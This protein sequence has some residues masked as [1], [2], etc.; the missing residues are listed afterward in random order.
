MLSYMYTCMGCVMVGRRKLALSVRGDLVD[1]VRRI[2]AERGES[3]SSI[4][5]EYLEY[6]AHARWIDTLAENLKLG[7]LK[8][9]TT[10]EI[11]K[12]RPKG[13]NTAKLIRELRDRRGMCH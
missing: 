12:N 2:V 8:P 11:P 7:P 13:L 5:E 9:T 10:S 3:L 4:V 1:E 6:L